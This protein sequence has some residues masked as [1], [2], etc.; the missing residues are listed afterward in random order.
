MSDFTTR[1]LVGRELYGNGDLVDTVKTYDKIYGIKPDICFNPDTNHY[2]ASDEFNA[3]IYLY[4][5]KYDLNRRLYYKVYKYIK[6]LVLKL[7]KGKDYNPFPDIMDTFGDCNHM[8]TH[9]T[10]NTRITYRTYGE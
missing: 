2:W 10:G 9:P 6:R 4:L 1:K 5:K 8:V 7:F 3:Y